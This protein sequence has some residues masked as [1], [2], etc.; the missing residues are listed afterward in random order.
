[1]SDEGATQEQMKVEGAALLH[2]IIKRR[3]EEQD[4]REPNPL[5][6]RQQD[7]ATPR[8]TVPENGQAS[9]R[10]IQSD[11]TVIFTTRDVN[12]P[13]PPTPG[14]TITMDIH[15]FVSFFQTMRPSHRPITVAGFV[16]AENIVAAGVELAGHTLTRDD[17][18]QITRSLTQLEEFMQAWP[19]LEALVLEYT[20]IMLRNKHVTHEQAADDATVMLGVFISRDAWRMRVKKWAKLQ[21]LPPV[22]QR[23]RKSTA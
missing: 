16:A 21:N 13:P 9:S 17:R 23:K 15:S 10:Y 22:E 5:M 6:P 8:F 18:L 4:A 20:Y 14:R 11:G 1:M 2:S 19:D 12:A 7:N 3:Q